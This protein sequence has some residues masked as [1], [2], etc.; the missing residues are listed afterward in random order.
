MP[1]A[2]NNASALKRAALL[3]A[4]VFP[5][6]AFAAGLNLLSLW[7]LL[8]E[9]I[10]FAILVWVVMKYVWP[11]LMNAVETRRKEIA[12]GLAAGERG[13]KDLEAAEQRKDELMA[14]ANAEA[15]KRLEESR[16]RGE[17]IIAQARAEAERE[18]ARIVAAGHQEVESEKSAMRREL[19]EKLSDL[20]VAGAAR[21]LGR[22]VENPDIHAG[23]VDSLKKEL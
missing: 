3:T 23:M 17:E 18:K 13:R 9:I 6:P 4:A 16:K 11:P 22:E 8:G 14:D 15:A 12:D 2:S 10:T 19:Q 21:I 20:V 1:P 5:A 7:T